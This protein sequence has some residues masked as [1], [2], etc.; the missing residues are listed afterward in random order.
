MTNTHT[1]YKGFRLN[2]TPVGCTSIGIWKV[3]T[4]RSFKHLYEGEKID[5]RRMIDDAVY[6]DLKALCSYIHLKSV[7]LKNQLSI[8]RIA[9]DDVSSRHFFII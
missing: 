5:K 8:R 4:L 7:L 3:I 2:F 9:W 1:L 6:A